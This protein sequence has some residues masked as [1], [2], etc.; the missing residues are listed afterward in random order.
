MSGEQQKSAWPISKF[1]FNVIIG[2]QDNPITFQEVSGLNLD[3]SI[4]EYRVGDSKV[5]SN[6]YKMPGIA[7][8]GIVTLKRGVFINYKSFWNWYNDF[9]KEIIIR[10]MVTIQLLDENGMPSMAWK[11]K[12]AWPTKIS[13]ANLR[14]DINEVA[15]ETLEFA[16]EGFV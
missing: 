4:F 10:E 1:S 15:V 5:F 16:H 12:D 3:S 2:L 8:S 11:L 14:P 9:E 6:D 13:I 7:T